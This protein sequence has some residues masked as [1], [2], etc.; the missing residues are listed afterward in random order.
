MTNLDLSGRTALVTGASSGLGRRFAK[1]LAAGGANVVLTARRLDRLEELKVEIEASGGRAL[2]AVLDVADEPSVVA[3]YDAAE[4]AF[5]PVDT[6]VANAGLAVDGRALDLSLADFDSIFSVNVRGVFL[7]LREGARR[8][9]AN[10]A[11]ERGNGRMVVISSITAHQVISRLSAYAA[12]KAAVAQ[13][14]RVMAKEWANKGINV[15]VLAP[16]YIAT[17]LNEQLWRGEAGERLLSGFARR[18]MMD[19]G[20]LDPLLLYLCSDLSAEVTGS[21][22]TVDDGQTL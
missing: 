15:N 3:A 11:P 4:T 20:A 12:S 14:S 19:L 10:G 8:M 22:F 5:G 21:V 9:I 2:A 7:T 13:M 18:R 6:V 1:I 16:G 17:E